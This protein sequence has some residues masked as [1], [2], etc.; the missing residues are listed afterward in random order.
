MAG[1]PIDIVP[2]IDKLVQAL[3]VGAT[4]ELAAQYAGISHDTFL[5]WRQR[6]PDAKD[7]TPLATLRDRLADAEGR[8]AVGWLAKIEAAATEGNWQAAAWKLERRY[9]RDY[10]KTVHEHIGDDEKPLS[11][12]IRRA[13]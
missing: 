13:H 10:G 4:Y 12:V 2:H 3:L 8:A 11:I 9:P 7:G 1:K 5:R 6:M